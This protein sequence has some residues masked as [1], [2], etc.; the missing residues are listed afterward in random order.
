[1]TYRFDC[2]VVSKLTHCGFHL[3]LGFFF[4]IPP[5]NGK[6]SNKK[7]F[8]KAIRED[9]CIFPCSSATCT[10]IVI[11][12][13]LLIPCWCQQAHI[14]GSCQTLACDVIV[15]CYV[16]RQ[17]ITVGIPTHILFVVVQGYSCLLA[18]FLIFLCIYVY[19]CTQ[20][21]PLLKSFSHELMTPVRALG[22]RRVGRSTRGKALLVHS[23]VCLN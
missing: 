18:V 16:T 19:V 6:N 2:A 10:T 12:I 4:Q 5:S 3:T 1:M 21:S 14:D 13:P 20:V 15:S 9:L 22:G 8:W 7:C 23:L 11:K 17:W